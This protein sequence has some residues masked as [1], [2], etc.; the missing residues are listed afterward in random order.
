MTIPRVSTTWLPPIAQSPTPPCA[1]GACTDFPLCTAREMSGLR[2][3]GNNRLELNFTLPSKERTYCEQRTNSVQW[4][5]IDC[6]CCTGRGARLSDLRFPV[7]RSE[8]MAA[9]T[10]RGVEG[11]SI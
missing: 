3:N 6:G 8:A 4:F 5:F 11:I 2:H 1:A 10:L 9:A 7:I